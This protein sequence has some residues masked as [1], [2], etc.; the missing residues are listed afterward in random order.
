MFCWCGC[1]LETLWTYLLY[2]V[3]MKE[4]RHL[5]KM[6]ESSLEAIDVLRYIVSDGPYLEGI[7]HRFVKRRV[8]RH[9][10]LFSYSGDYMMIFPQG[11]LP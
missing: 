7:V 9:S 4:T 8:L 2:E 6:W 1:I 10:I 11:S 5:S 3:T